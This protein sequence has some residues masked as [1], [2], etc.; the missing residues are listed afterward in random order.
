MTLPREEAQAGRIPRCQGAPG[1]PHG[2]RKECIWKLGSFT[3]LSVLPVS[4]VGFAQPPDDKKSLSGDFYNIKS[5]KEN[6]ASSL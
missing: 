5:Q 6:V 4:H 2:G 1:A 3:S